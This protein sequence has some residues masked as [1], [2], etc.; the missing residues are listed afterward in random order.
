MTTFAVAWATVRCAECKRT[1]DHQETTNVGVIEFWPENLGPC[2][3]CF[4]LGVRIE[5]GV[6]EPDDAAAFFDGVELDDEELG[7]L[8]LQLQHFRAFR[9][10]VATWVGR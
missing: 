9:Q 5:V 3:H 2:P 1:R 4:Q 10:M 8:R 7:F 6:R